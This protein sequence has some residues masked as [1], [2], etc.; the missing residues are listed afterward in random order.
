MQVLRCRAEVYPRFVMPQLGKH[1]HYTHLARSS[2][3]HL[4]SWINSYKHA[5]QMLGYVPQRL[6]PSTFLMRCRHR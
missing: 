4:R 1:R 5:T 3:R 2:R 6:K